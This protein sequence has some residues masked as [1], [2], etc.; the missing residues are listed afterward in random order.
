MSHDLIN[1][2]SLTDQLFLSNQTNLEKEMGFRPVSTKK[3]G[4]KKSI[5]KDLEA[6]VSKGPISYNL[7]DWRK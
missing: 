3:S 7:S 2:N 1:V 5:D 6:I 4:P